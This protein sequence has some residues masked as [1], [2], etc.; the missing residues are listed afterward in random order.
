MVEGN[1]ERGIENNMISEE[2]WWNERR[3]HG[4]AEMRE[5]QAERQLHSSGN[6]RGCK[7]LE[8]LGGAM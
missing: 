8:K 5:K 2:L 6:A 1:E 3:M 7:E 4:S